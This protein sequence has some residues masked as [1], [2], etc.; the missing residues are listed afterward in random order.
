MDGQTHRGGWVVGQT[1]RR[2]DVKTNEQ[3]DGRKNLMDKQIDGRVDLRT[4]GEN[5]GRK[6][7]TDGQMD[8]RRRHLWTGGIGD[9]ERTDGPMA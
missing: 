8:G 4:D 9:A 2:T 7:W 6:G 3:K 1:G 5:D